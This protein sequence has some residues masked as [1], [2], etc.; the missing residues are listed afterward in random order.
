RR[1]PMKSNLL[2]AILAVLIVAPVFAQTL[3]GPRP[4][5]EIASI[6][7]HVDAGPGP[8]LTG[9]QHMPGSP[10]MDMMGVTFKMLM[11]Y[12]YA[13]QDFQIIGGPDWIASE[14]Y[15][16]QA[17]AQDGS[18]PVSTGMRDINIP[19]SMALRIQSLLD[20]RFQLETHRETREAAVYE[21][22]MA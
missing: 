5:F 10:R 2:L 19:D 15:D 14:R 22:T 8:G 6:K 16:I 20:D 1:E 4:V 9:F 7:L 3:S 11:E 13:V 12:V 17:K 21:L 18:V